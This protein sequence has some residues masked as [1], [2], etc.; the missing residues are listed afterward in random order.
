MHFMIVHND[1]IWRLHFE[2]GREKTQLKNVWNHILLQWPMM[3]G[4][5]MSL[6]ELAPCTS[7]MVVL[8]RHRY[9]CVERLR[10]LEAKYGN[11][12]PDKLIDVE[13][14]HYCDIPIAETRIG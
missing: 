4:L 13:C 12:R 9:Q 11:H 10:Y 1:A 5:K 7:V 14:R 2:M 3:A 8:A 6:Q